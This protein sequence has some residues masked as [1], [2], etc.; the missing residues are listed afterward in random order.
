[1]MTAPQESLAE[2]EALV[3]T[4][5]ATTDESFDDLELIETT[6][7][8]WWRDGSNPESATAGPQRGTLA[9]LAAK[10]TRTTTGTRAVCLSAAILLVSTFAIFN[11]LD[12]PKLLWL[13]KENGDGRVLSEEPCGVQVGTAVSRPLPEGTR[14]KQIKHY[15]HGTGLIVNLHVTHHGGTTVSNVIGRAPNTDGCPAF[16]CDVVKPEDGVDN[17]DVWP[18]SKYYHPWEH[19]KTAEN[20]ALTRPYFHFVGWENG[21]APKLPFSETNWEGK[22]DDITRRD[23]FRATAVSSLLVVPF[24]TYTRP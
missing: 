20:I 8:A 18:K 3:G 19:D 11:L 10:K 12:G 17:M 22:N 21:A 9:A 5:K 1:M 2:T 15:R 6:S 16:A 14:L 7:P 4:V 23:R 24:N 13:R